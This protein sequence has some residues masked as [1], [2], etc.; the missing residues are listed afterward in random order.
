VQELPRQREKNLAQS[1]TLKEKQLAEQ[2]QQSLVQERQALKTELEKTPP[3]RSMTIVKKMEED[4]QR[5]AETE[6]GRKAAGADR[7][8]TA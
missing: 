5:Q 7:K 6:T 1:W 3:Q 8:N 2:Y 4:L